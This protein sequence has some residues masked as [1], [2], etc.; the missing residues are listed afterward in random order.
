[1]ARVALEHDLAGAYL[2][3]G[4]PELSGWWID[5]QTGA[6]LRLRLDWLTRLPDGRWIVVDY[7]TS[8][9][10]GRRAFA[11]AAG[12]YGYFMQQPFYV[13][14]LRALGIE[15]ADFVFIT[16]RKTPPY[17]I[18]VAR[19]DAADI[20]LG[21][22]CNRRAIEIFA[23]CM[24]ADEWPDDSHEIPTVCIPAWTRYRAEELLA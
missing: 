5:E 11:K 23:D 8:K 18:T 19:V 21:R 22:R 15:V 10:S 3:E 6:R 2:A 9:S 12:E 16:Q 14:G 7:K 1:M 4:D 24:A 20:E 17:R 13:D